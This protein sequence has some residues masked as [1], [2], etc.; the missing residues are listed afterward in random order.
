MTQEAFAETFRFS[1]ESVQAWEY[2]RWVP[3]PEIK[4]YLRVIDRAPDTV[5]DALRAA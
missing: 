1:L 3:S 4:A 5:Q 2:G